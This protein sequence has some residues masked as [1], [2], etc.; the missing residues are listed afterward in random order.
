[1]FANWLGVYLDSDGDDRVDWD[2]IA[3]IVEDAFRTVAPKTLPAD[4]KASDPADPNYDFAYIDREIKLAHQ[5]GLTPLVYIE[6]T[7]AWAS[8]EIDGGT[9]ASP[10]LLGQFARAA[11]R[12]YS[13]SFQGLPRVRYW[14]AWNEPNNAVT[15]AEQVSVVAHLVNSGRV[16]LTGNFRGAR[17]R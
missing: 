8:V 13:G 5:R 3:G 6:G 14:Q 15:G 17:L 10:K 9:R 16:R 12:R 7:P 4:F 2:E 11:A 1:M